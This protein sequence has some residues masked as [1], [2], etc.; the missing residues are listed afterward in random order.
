[1][2]NNWPFFTRGGQIAWHAQSC[3]KICFAAHHP[4]DNAKA[5]AIPFRRRTRPAQG[6]NALLWEYGAKTPT[7]SQCT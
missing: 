5:F 2:K 1:M 7:P 4:K 6:S 3:D